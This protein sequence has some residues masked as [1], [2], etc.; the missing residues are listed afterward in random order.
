MSKHFN[1]LFDKMY[2]DKKKEKYATSKNDVLIDDRKKY[3]TAFTNGGGTAIMHSEPT[4]T[5]EQMKMM[6]R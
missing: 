3:V 1:G 5:I 6:T 2:V 4:S